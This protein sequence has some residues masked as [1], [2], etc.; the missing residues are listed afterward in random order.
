MTIFWNCRILESFRSVS[1]ETTKLEFNLIKKRIKN[2][3]SV[4][5]VQKKCFYTN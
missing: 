5:S 4:F 2:Y 1:K 3:Y